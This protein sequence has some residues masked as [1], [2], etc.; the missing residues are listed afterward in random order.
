MQTQQDGGAQFSRD[1]DAA[2]FFGKDRIPLGGGSNAAL[3]GML[4][5]GATLCSSVRDAGRT[6]AGERQIYVVVNLGNLTDCGIDSARQFFASQL[7]RA[8]IETIAELYDLQIRFHRGEKLREDFVEFTALL[9]ASRAVGAE[10]SF[11]EGVREAVDVLRRYARG[12][13]L[14]DA[15]CLLRCSSVSVETQAGVVIVPLCGCFDGA[16]IPCSIY[17]ETDERALVA[18]NISAQTLGGESAAARLRVLDQDGMLGR[19]LTGI[20]QAQCGGV[21]FSVR[22]PWQPEG[23][24]QAL[25][26]IEGNLPSGE[27]GWVRAVVA[28]AIKDAVDFVLNRVPQSS[29]EHATGCSELQFALGLGLRADEMMKHARRLLAEQVS[30]PDSPREAVAIGERQAIIRVVPDASAPFLGAPELMEKLQHNLSESSLAR[31]AGIGVCYRVLSDG[32]ASAERRSEP[33]PL[34]EVFV[35]LFSSAPHWELRVD[36]GRNDR[37]YKLAALALFLDHFF[38]TMRTGVLPATASPI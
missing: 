21:N 13:A 11:E 16:F 5:D 10:R 12:E 38:V 36:F 7:C 4:G 28:A 32:P 24:S 33:M 31:E 8:Q 30:Q 3:K 17:E 23:L 20:L 29:E 1:P 34:S 27:P 19:E 18:V 15:T 25:I 2:S 6:G 14:S 37:E 22:G 35:Q 26:R 9:P